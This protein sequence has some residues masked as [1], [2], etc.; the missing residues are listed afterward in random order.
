MQAVVLL[1]LFKHWAPEPRELSQRLE[2]QRSSRRA[3][4]GTAVRLPALTALLL[5][6]DNMDQPEHVLA[7]LTTGSAIS[8]HSQRPSPHCAATTV[9]CC[10]VPPSPIRPS[11]VGLTTMFAVAQL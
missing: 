5:L 10:T 4:A 8:I 2:E 9:I 1:R 3:D 6:V 11:P 7:K